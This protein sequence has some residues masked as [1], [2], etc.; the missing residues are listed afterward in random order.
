MMALDGTSPSGV[1]TANPVIPM[2][3][4]VD[5]SFAVL[6][7]D[8]NGD[9]VVN[10]QDLVGVRNEVLGITADTV[11]GNLNGDNVVDINDYEAVQNASEHISREA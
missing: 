9:G 11:W 1:H 10:S 6:P 2:L 8:F 7:G 4:N 5:L 3:A